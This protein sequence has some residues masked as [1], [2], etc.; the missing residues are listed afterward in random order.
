MV[1]FRTLLVEDTAFCPLFPRL[2][3]YCD[4]LHPNWAWVL[5][6]MEIDAP[7]TGWCKHS[8]HSR[9]GND[10]Q[11]EYVEPANGCFSVALHVQDQ[12]VN[13]IGDPFGNLFLLHLTEIIS[14]RPFL[15]GL[16][17]PSLQ[18]H[19]HLADVN[20]VPPGIFME[21]VGQ[22]PF[23]HRQKAGTVV[24]HSAEG[25]AK[26]AHLIL[27]EV[28]KTQIYG[29]RRK[30]KEPPSSSNRNKISCSGVKLMFFTCWCVA[31][32]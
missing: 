26:I 12:L 20:E 21:T 29:L 19:I 4:Q 7:K 28:G 13:F 27:R 1:D 15:C 2:L 23:Q 30:V 25:P 17:I 22:L 3:C 10:Y 31:M 8:E 14:V 32:K 5:I 16:L 9:I 11:N 18:I 24:L 6:W